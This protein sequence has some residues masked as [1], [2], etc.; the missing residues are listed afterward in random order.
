[1]GFLNNFRKSVT[2]FAIKRALNETDSNSAK[3]VLGYFKNKFDDEQYAVFEHELRSFMLENGIEQPPRLFRSEVE[4][5]YWYSRYDGAEK[6]PADKLSFEIIE[7]MRKSGVCMFVLEMKR[8]DIMKLFLNNRKYRLSGGSKNMRR[9]AEANVK[10]IMPK[11]ADEFTYSAMIYGTSM[12]ELTAVNKTEKQLG[13]ENSPTPNK[14][15]TVFKTPSFVKPTSIKEIRRTVNGDF[16]GFVQYTKYSTDKKDIVVPVDQA[17][18]VPYQSHFKNLWGE[19]FFTLLYPYWFWFEVTL[20]SMI[21]YLER[22]ATPVAIGRAPNNKPTRIPGTKTMVDSMVYMR[23][24]L[25]DIA[26]TAGAILP[27]TVDRDSSKYEWDV[28]YLSTNQS[29]VNF[30][31]AL[32]FFIE[33]MFRSAGS[34]DR[35]YTQSS[36][37]VGSYSIGEI[38]REATQ[39][40]T[41]LILVS[42]LH[43]INEYFIS[44][45]SI[46]NEGMN[47]IPLK[48]E[49]VGISYEEKDIMTKVLSTAGNTTATE[50]FF[51]SV[52]WKSFAEQV[53]IPTLSK[54]ESIRLKEELLSYEIRKANATQNRSSTAEGDSG[55]SQRRDSGSEGDSSTEEGN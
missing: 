32:N 50:E 43:Y 52:D 22:S 42:F 3:D 46:L 37:G 35:S 27:S 38:H 5:D 39:S 41:E 44:K 29:S 34:A 21:R 49:T 12:A 19:S 45:Y 47:S 23:S 26:K 40:H 16:N 25:E 48:L 1:M 4:G 6:R 36:G 31:E 55:E 17:L 11:M 33:M 15:W 30:I 10:S 13:I 9:V 54:E 28:Q 20:R 24:V 7:R 53:G 18:V 51:I 14:V 2:S 8:S